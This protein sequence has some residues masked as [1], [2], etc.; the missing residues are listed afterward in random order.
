MNKSH[1]CILFI[2][3]FFFI[4]GPVFAG[5]ND[6]VNLGGAI[7]RDLNLSLNANQSCMTCHHP[8]A[9][10]A[11][12][13]NR[14][15]PALFPVSDGSDPALFGGRNA[16]EASYAGFSPIFHFDGELFVGGLFWDGRATGRW[17]LRLPENWE[18]APPA[19]R[20][21]TRPKDLSGTRW[22]WRCQ[23]KM[24]RDD[25]PEEAVVAIIQ[26]SDYAANLKKNSAPTPSQ[27][28]EQHITTQASPSLPSKDPKM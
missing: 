1:V 3:A 14:I 23:G 7:Y 9:G 15:S 28:S 2:L 19:T 24:N 16:P 18:A 22:K 17:T 21:P 6:L 5:P 27:M 25:S 13:E 20:W 11:D 8:S 4:A 12:P 26:A 10:F